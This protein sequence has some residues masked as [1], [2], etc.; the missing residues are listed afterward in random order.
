MTFAEKLKALRRE[1][2]LSERR[3]ARV[4]GIPYGTLHTYALGIR[5]PSFDNVVR[6]ARVLQ[7]ACETFA[8]CEDV[9]ND[10]PEPVRRKRRPGRSRSRKRRAL[11]S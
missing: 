8:T 10:E 1:M 6:I 5:K 7:V 4:A 2:A 3:L 11:T 9:A